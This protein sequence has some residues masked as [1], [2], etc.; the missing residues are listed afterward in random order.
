[1]HY[2][3]GTIDEPRPPGIFRCGSPLSPAP[4]GAGGICPA[5]AGPAVRTSGTRPRPGARAPRRPPE[6]RDLLRIAHDSGARTPPEPFA[7]EGLTAG[8]A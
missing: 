6:P 1:M 2:A 5:P 4:R 8:E 3:T 7:D